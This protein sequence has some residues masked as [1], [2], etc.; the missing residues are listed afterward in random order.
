MKLHY[1]HGRSPLRALVMIRQQRRVELHIKAVGDE[2]W[3]VVALSGIHGST[4]GQPEKHRCQGPYGSVAGAESAMR[5]LA[6]SLMGEGFE[7]C[8]GEHVVWP[9]IAQRLARMVR[10]D[11]AMSRG[12]GHFDPDRYE[13]IG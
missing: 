12:D 9:V 13:P 1:F 2:A 5:R 6:G 4:V 10:T 3:M 11:G 7:P 8:P